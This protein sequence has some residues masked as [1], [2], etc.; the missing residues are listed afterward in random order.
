MPGTYQLLHQVYNREDEACFQCRQP[1]HSRN[2]AG[3]Q[4]VLLPEVPVVTTKVTS[5]TLLAS[6]RVSLAISTMK[7]F[8]SFADNTVLE[9]DTGL[10]AVVGPNGSGKSNVVDAVTWVLVSRA[11]GRCVARRWDDVIFSLARPIV[12][13]SGAPKSP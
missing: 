6:F 8:K 1:I 7:G 3:A 4:H 10:T 13:H 12:R 9:F 2:G 5:R 11:R